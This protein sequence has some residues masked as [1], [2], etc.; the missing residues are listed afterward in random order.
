MLE[1][2]GFTDWDLQHLIYVLEDD[3]NLFGSF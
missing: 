3:G 2:L 1:R